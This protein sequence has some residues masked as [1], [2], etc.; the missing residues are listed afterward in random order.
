MSRPTSPTFP[1]T[2]WHRLTATRARWP[3]S[4]SSWTR[5]LRIRRTKW[6]WF[7]LFSSTKLMLFWLPRLIVFPCVSLV[8]VITRLRYFDTL[9]NVQSRTTTLKEWFPHQHTLTTNPLKLQNIWYKLVQKLALLRQ[10][11]MN[12]EICTPNASSKQKCLRTSLRSPYSIEFFSSLI[13]SWLGVLDWQ[14][15]FSNLSLKSNPPDSS[16]L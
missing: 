16:S 7:L 8:C 13:S 5:A 10:D 11:R 6:W 12:D 2:V 4:R 9:R 15:V 1:M 3:A 14:P